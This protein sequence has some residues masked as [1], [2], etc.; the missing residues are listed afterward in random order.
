MLFDT[1]CHLDQDAFDPDRRGVVERAAAAGVTRLLAVGV[2]AESSRACVGLAG[3]F[4]GVW[5]AVGVQPNYVHLAAPGDWDEVLRL[6]GEQRVVA[7][8]ETGLDRYWDDAPFDLQEDYFDRHLRLSQATGLP[9]IVH[10]RECGD[11]VAR[12]LR[13]ARARGPLRGVMHSYT[14]D[15]DLARECL[16]LG[17]HIS[18]AGMLTYKKSDALRGV[19][20]GVPADRLL[21]ETDSPYL[22][23]EPVRKVRRNEPAHLVHTC[24]ALAAARGDTTQAVARATTANALALFRRASAGG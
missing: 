5:A 13:E 14:G 1:H 23:P 20:A 4:P 18:F 12:M 16:E 24:A 2:S 8:G 17:L 6:S 9:F 7:L 21:L 22:S 3:E 19:A 10:M 11:D 15:A